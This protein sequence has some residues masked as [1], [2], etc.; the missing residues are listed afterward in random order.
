MDTCDD[1]RTRPTECHSMWALPRIPETA[2]YETFRVPRGKSTASTRRLAVLTK[3]TQVVT[4]I[5]WSRNGRLYAYYNSPMLR[6]CP[7]HFRHRYLASGS[8]DTSILL[9]EHASVSGNFISSCEEMTHFEMDAQGG[10]AFQRSCRVV[11][12]S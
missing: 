4:C 11:L 5:R 6:G 12:E 1:I 2:T 10:I 9:W 7:C 8:D 3:H